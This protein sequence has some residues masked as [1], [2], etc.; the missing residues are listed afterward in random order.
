MTTS[1]AVY[2]EERAENE[3]STKE[4]I[5]DRGTLKGAAAVF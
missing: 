4:K 5:L 1:A 2:N 3:A